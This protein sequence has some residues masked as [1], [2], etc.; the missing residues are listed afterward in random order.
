MDP[1]LEAPAP[2]SSAHLGHSLE[3]QAVH[4]AFWTILFSVVN[5][6]VTVGSQ[7]A[8]AW[9][10]LPRDMGLVAMTFSVTSLVTLI[11]GPNLTKLL[12]QRPDRFR[13]EA[14]QAFWL[15]LSLNLA[16][17]LA[18]VLIS[19]LAAHLFK[20]PRVIGLI[21]VTAAA[22]P[23]MALPTIYAAA[24]YRDL[25][26]KNIAVMHCGEGI[27]RN[28]L[29]VVLAALGFG[30]YALVLPLVAGALFSASVFRW[31]AGPIPLQ[32]PR[33][34]QWLALLAPAGWLMLHTFFTAIQT[35]GTSLVLGVVHNSTVTG[36][37]YWGFALST[38]ALFLLAANLQTVLF[39]A[40][41][42]VNHDGPRQYAAFRNASSA[43]MLVAVPVCVLQVLLARPALHLFFQERWWPAAPVVQWLSLGMLTQPLTVLATSLLL[44]RGRFGMLAALTG[45]IALA[46]LAAAV[47]GAWLGQQI[48]I[49]QWS[50]L[51]LF[52]T[53][54]LAGWIGLRQFGHGWR[55]LARLVALPFALTPVCLLAGW[56]IR[57]L[58]PELNP[59]ALCAVT[60]A[61][62]VALYL[63]L[64][65][66]FVPAVIPA[67]LDFW[68]RPPVKTFPQEA[69]P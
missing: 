37:Y 9:L 30:P 50:C 15:S 43:L 36:L 35:Y 61:V 38:Q 13:E 10:L 51:S 12:I 40:L 53:G 54:L 44:A 21:L 32:A 57:W 4:G 56:A 19:P 41:S 39:P 24:L 64:V 14:A 52:L 62:I 6:I 3:R 58:A 65:R 48:Q 33:P 8:L 34:S 67:P 28:V 1:S 26:F 31:Q 47:V 18:L 49:A 5:K 22:T 20:E 27:L 63:F 60:G 7:V 66:L 45:G 42:R 11:C 46:T 55:E 17:A 2:V 29:A 16:A 69:T 68:R 23:L 25:R 59:F